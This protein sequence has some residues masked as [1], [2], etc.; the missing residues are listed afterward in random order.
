LIDDAF[1]ERDKVI[2][3]QDKQDQ[4]KA[5]QSKLVTQE[6]VTYSAAPKA[7]P[8]LTIVVGLVVISIAYIA[9]GK[10]ASLEKK[11]TLEI[12]DDVQ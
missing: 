12:F 4:K 8:V 11:H 3:D 5:N 2:L 9:Q 10:A 7:S 1:D 6:P